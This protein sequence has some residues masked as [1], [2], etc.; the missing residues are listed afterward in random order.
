MRL[1]CVLNVIYVVISIIQS[2]DIQSV[3]QKKRFKRI[4][5]VDGITEISDT[6]QKEKYPYIVGIK[7]VQKRLDSR[8]WKSLRCA[9]TLLS[10]NLVLTTDYCVRN[11]VSITVYI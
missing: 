9:G 3:M 7:T 10:N 4:V 1:F 5:N 11:A 2:T 8:V 6:E